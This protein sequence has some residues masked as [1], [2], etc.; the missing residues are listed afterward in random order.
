MFIRNI[1]LL[2]IACLLGGCDSA[3]DTPAGHVHGEYI[4]RT[5]NEFL[6]TT[7]APQRTPVAPYP[8]EEESPG[9]HPKITKEFFRCKGSTL[10]SPRVVV[11]KNET[12]RHFDCGGGDAHSLPLC[13]GKE[14][15][16]PILLS[17]LNDV[18]RQTGKKVIIT[19]GHR[20]PEHNAYVDPSRGNQFSK[21]QIGAEVSFYVRGMEEQPEK[22]VAVV[23]KYYLETDKYGGQKEYQDFLRWDKPTDVRTAPWYNKEVFVKV[24]QKDEGRNY[25]NR[26]P[27]PY[28]SIQVRYDYDAKEKVQYSWDKAFR[29]YM[30]W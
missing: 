18:Q 27:Y 16:Y 2:L 7:E 5:Q 20:C 15:V 11:E 17:L 22:V 6:F 3:E 13:D 30:R 25:D 9:K 24:Y 4:N 21:H 29:N 28:I 10:N 23:K 1:A 26:H 19:S 12:K 14:F 8:W